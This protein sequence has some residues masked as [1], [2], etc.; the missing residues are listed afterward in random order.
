MLTFKA[1]KQETSLP[2]TKA[3]TMIWPSKTKSS[4]PLKRTKGGTSK[5]KTIYKLSSWRRR[6]TRTILNKSWMFTMKKLINLSR[7]SLETEGKFL[8]IRD[9]LRTF[10]IYSE[11]KMKKGLKLR[12]ISTK[13]EAHHKKHIKIRCQNKTKN[14]WKS[15]YRIW[16]MLLFKHMLQKIKKV[17]SRNF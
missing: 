1:H 17:C 6:S 13:M 11:M 9:M 10:L 2:Q 5:K 16:L 8:T 15:G 12:I 3:A 4:V 14:K 7:K